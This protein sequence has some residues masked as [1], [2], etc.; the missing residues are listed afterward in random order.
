MADLKIAAAAKALTMIE[1]REDKLM[2]KRNDDFVMARGKFPR[3]RQKIAAARLKEI[4][5]LVLAL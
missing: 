4:K 1:V 3:L 5:K 2:L